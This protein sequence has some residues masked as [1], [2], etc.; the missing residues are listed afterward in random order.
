[1]LPLQLHG[2]ITAYCRAK[3]IFMPDLAYSA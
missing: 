3:T 1:L 2:F